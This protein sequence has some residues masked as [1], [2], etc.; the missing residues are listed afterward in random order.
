MGGG[1]L[2][3][4]ERESFVIETASTSVF[5]ENEDEV[6]AFPTCREDLRP[7]EIPPSGDDIDGDDSA[8]FRAIGGDRALPFGPK[9]A[10]EEDP[11]VGNS[12]SV[13]REETCLN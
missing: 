13:A 1:E 9:R 3:T 11:F 6:L 2:T 7:G 8:V 4:C 10:L 5:C 12:L